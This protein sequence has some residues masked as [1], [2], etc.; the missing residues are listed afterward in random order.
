[1]GQVAGKYFVILNYHFVWTRVVISGL[2]VILTQRHQL[3]GE[4]QG[5]MYLLI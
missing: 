3:L 1:M 2:H 5:K 4:V